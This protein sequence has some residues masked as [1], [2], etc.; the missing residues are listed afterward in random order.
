MIMLDTVKELL[1]SLVPCSHLAA[2]NFLTQ[3]TN[4]TN[5]GTDG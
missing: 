5:E 1:E 3:L 2:S 4:S